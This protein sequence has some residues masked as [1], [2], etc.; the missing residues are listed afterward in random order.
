MGTREETI[1]LWGE[2]TGIST[3]DIAWY[4]DFTALKLALLTVRMTELHAVAV[5]AE[6]ANPINLHLAKRLGIAWP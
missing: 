2:I 6:Q 4:E 3:A 1:V 5:T